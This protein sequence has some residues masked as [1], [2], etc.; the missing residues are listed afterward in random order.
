MDSI[1]TIIDT[2][3]ARYALRH[4]TNPYRVSM[5]KSEFYWGSN[6]VTA[7]Q[8]M[9]LLIGFMV[10]GKSAYKDAAI[11]T[12]DYLLGRNP[13]GYCFVTGAGDRMV[14]NVHH[15][16]SIADNVIEP[17]PG[18]LCGG[19]NSKQNEFPSCE[20]WN[21]CPQY[22]FP[23][24]VKVAM[25]YVDQAESYASNEVAINWNAPLVFLCGGCEALQRTTISAV[26]KS[27]NISEDVM[28]PSVYFRRAGSFA[29]ELPD[30]YKGSASMIDLRGK[31][32]LRTK[33]NGNSLVTISSDRVRRTAVIILDVVDAREKKHRFVY[34][35]FN[36][37]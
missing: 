14:M 11:S 1:I 13:N 26:K 35:I 24:G 31:V 4:Q 30:G 32:L 29:V 22:P 16:P 10:T 28:N 37:D 5:V 34:K 20:D 21:G 8:G 36:T 23:K 2:L 19:P 6:S 9:L 15:R 12:L 27:Y 3:A 18:F 7:N 33:L 25:S 17:V